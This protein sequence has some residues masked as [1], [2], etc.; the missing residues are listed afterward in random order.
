M[1]QAV[2]LPHAD[3]GSMYV[4]RAALSLIV[5]CCVSGS[6]LALYADLGSVY[7]RRAAL[8]LIVVFQ[9]VVLPHAD[10]GSVYVRRAAL[11]LIV[12]FRAVGLPYMLTSAECEK[13]LH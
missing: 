4:R 3:L 2:G 8:S 12:V 9:A 10:L 6:G 11:S 5:D 7:V 13:G 1:F